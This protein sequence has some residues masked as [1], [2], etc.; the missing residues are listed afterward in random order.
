MEQ[1]NFAIVF[2]E[3]LLSILSPCILPILPIYLSMLSNSS[4]TDIKQ[5]SF[6]KSRL[7]QNTIFF[8]LGISTT[9]FILGSSVR[10]LSD[11]FQDYRNYIMLFGGV[12]IILMGLF[13]TGIIKISF[14]EKE[15]RFQMKEK[16]M[17][18]ITAFVLGFTFSFG[19][20][21][22]IGPVLAS[23]LILASGSESLVTSN[24]L[25]FVYTLGF[26]LPFIITAMFYHKLYY[27]FDKMKEHMKLIK[28]ISGV[29]II[30]AGVIML[31]TGGMKLNDQIKIQSN[32]DSQNTQSTENTQNNETLDKEENKEEEKEKIAPIDFTL[33]DQYGIS[34]KLSDYKGK[35]VFLNFWATWCPPCRAEMP[36]MEELYQEYN[37]N[38][39]DVVILGVASPNLGNEKDIEYIKN[40][41]TEEGHT[42]PVV[43][44]ENVHLVEQY[45]INAFPSTFIINE[46]GYITR[47]IPGAMDKKTMKYLIEEE[48]PEK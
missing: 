15:K 24:L 5:A 27:K 33:V 44:D 22:C 19:W 13:Y 20:T 47:Y 10:F 12:F 23:V 45:G 2:I 3:G 43:F 21:P 32:K 16:A 48:M 37:Q 17:N 9:F 28:S 8:T 30:F 6:R 31:V 46:E 14:M 34:H 39:D 11:F 41:L 42:F 1:I 35:T 36:H 4:V 25:I 40:F 29:V 26:I 38:Q 7:I 18:P